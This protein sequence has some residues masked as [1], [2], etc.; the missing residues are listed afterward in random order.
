MYGEKSS[1]S[2]RKV[3]LVWLCLAVF[4]TA[5]VAES[6]HVHPSSN[7]SEHNCSLCI[8]VHSVAR[9]VAVATPVAAP[10]QCSA[11]LSPAAQL[12]PDFQSLFAL[13]IRPPPVA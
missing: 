9:P 10:S 2:G 13:Y 5:C 8:A 6:A 3:W 12:L 4:A 11:V 7:P 1:L